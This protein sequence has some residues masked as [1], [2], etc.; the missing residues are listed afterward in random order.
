M[1]LSKKQNSVE[2]LTFGFEFTALKLAVKLVIAFRHKLR[3][4][5]VPLEGPTDIFCDNK[6]VF[7]NTF[8]PESVLRKKHHIISYHKYREA[9]ATLIFRIAK[10][11]TGS[12]LADL[13]TKM[14]GLTRR[15]W[16]LNLFTY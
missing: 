1:W 3:M 6:T 9:V 10:E 4:F 16:L 2:T 11:Y 14:L 5:G 12:H 8:T 15:E 7:K 13:F